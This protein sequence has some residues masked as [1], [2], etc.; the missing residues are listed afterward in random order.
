VTSE[1]QPTSFRR[2]HE[3]EPITRDEA[4]VSLTSDDNA[5]VAHTLVRMSHHLDDWRWV[6]AECLRI[7]AS[8]EDP[9]SVAA[10]ATSLG[11]LARIHRQIDAQT[12]IP[13]LETLMTSDDRSVAGHAAIALD[14]IRQFVGR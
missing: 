13:L 4:I 9:V 1:Q 7:I 3:V 12:V 5:T 6:E 8:R 10:A 11:H 14:D 2:Y